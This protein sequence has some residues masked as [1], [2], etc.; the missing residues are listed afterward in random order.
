M[1]RFFFHVYDDDVAYDDEGRDFP[2]AEAA[3][4]EAIK[5]ACELMCEQLRKGSLALNHRV[6]VEDEAGNPV[7][8][9]RFGELVNIES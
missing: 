3:K 7:A 5:G 9:M 6:V 4:R 2:D 8:T 1:P